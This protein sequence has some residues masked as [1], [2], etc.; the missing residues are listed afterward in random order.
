MKRSAC[1]RVA[2]EVLCLAAALGATLVG[3]S[4]SRPTVRLQTERGEH[5][6]ELPTARTPVEVTTEE[7]SRAMGGLVLD[8]PRLH[9]DPE[10]RPGTEPRFSVRPISAKQGRLNGLTLAAWPSASVPPLTRDY[11]LWCTHTRGTGDCLSLLGNSLELDED[12]RHQLALALAFGSVWE[13]TRGALEAMVDPVAVRATLVSAMTFYLLALV[14]PEPVTKPVA[15]A[16]TAFLLSYLG[17]DT[18][19]GLISG[20]SELKQSASQATTFLE[21]RAAGSRYAKAIGERAARLFVMLATAALGATGGLATK[22]PA[23]P[24]FTQAALAA[25]TQYG[26]RLTA[27][28]EVQAV[29]VTR[30]GVSLILAP[31]VTAMAAQEPPGTDTECSGQEHHVISRPIAKELDRHLTLSGHYTARDPRFVV[32]A[33]DQASHWGYQDWHRKLDETVI[34]WLRENPMATVEQFE[35]F[36]RQLYLRPDLHHRFPHGF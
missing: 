30:G 19:W 18:F 31:G 16:L 11:A 24:G 14:A 28:S 22:G 25:E 20:W 7:F 2:W 17:W 4:T 36:L 1:K 8:L 6:R 35:A 29:A 3:C 33:R 9:A 34:R 23:L 15:V 26:I 5:V 13:E 32:Q 27:V 21:L 10:H 12:G